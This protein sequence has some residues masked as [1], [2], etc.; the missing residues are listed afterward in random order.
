MNLYDARVGKL[1]S[2]M[3]KDG[4]KA[5]II[6]ATDPHLSE[7][8]CSHYGAVRFYFCAFQGEDGTLLVTQDQCYLYTDGRYWTEAE[9]EL[10]NTSCH[11]IPAGKP[12]IPSMEDYIKDN[13][14]YP[15]GLDASLFTR[16]QISAFRKD[17]DSKIFSLSYASEVENLPSLPKDKIRKVDEKLFD[18]NQESRVKKILAM[19]K[20]DGAEDVFLTA[21]DDIAYVLGY[22]GSDIPDTPVFYSYLYLCEDQTMDFFIDFDK[23]PDGFKK[24]GTILRAH[25]YESVFDFLKSRIGRKVLV[26]PEKTNAKILQSISAPVYGRSPAYLL[27]AVKGPVE[28]ENTIRV[29]ALDG[30][31]VLKLMKYLDDNI[32]S[33]TLTERNIALYLDGLR[34]GDLECFSPSFET[35]AA[36]DSNAA[37]MHYAPTDTKSSKVTRDNELLLVDSG[38]HYFGG[39][40]DITRTFVLN[41]EP[42]HQVKHDYTLTLKSHI[43]LANTVFEDGCTG[44]SLDLAA[45]EVMWKE[46]LDYK[47]GTGHGVGYM[48]CVH[49]GP[50]G[51]RYYVRPGV[52]DSDKLVPGHIITD[53]P[54]VYKD[55]QYGI[56][57]ENELLVV[58]KT[59]SEDDQGIFLGFEPISYVPFDLRAIDTEMLTDEELDWLNSYN[60]LVFRKLAPLA[61]KDP[62]PDLFDYLSEYTRGLRK[63]IRNKGREEEAS[64]ENDFEEEMEE[65]NP[66]KEEPA[67]KE[68]PNVV[69]PSLDEPGYSLSSTASPNIAGSPI[70]NLSGEEENK[71]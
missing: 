11:L 68:D 38:G 69:S 12:G 30:L 35:I 5:Y 54:G 41:K 42:S 59:V 16:R 53:E 46:G 39:T 66:A 27:K 40:T 64:E 25:P 33:G 47:C 15:L 14:L 56:R 31:K 6:P 22:R 2:R 3:V 1:Q 29:Q 26:D 24:T 43:D 34:K 55:G 37:M 17:K 9:Q 51:F 58:K 4:I 63:E 49:E 44:H 10:H 23:L 28:I 18:D 48:L 62:D 45:R 19:A 32:D 36:V 8:Y 21:L 20:K 13:N 52:D 65:L 50:I 57:L 7:A 67:P 61:K 60:R 71:K 70:N